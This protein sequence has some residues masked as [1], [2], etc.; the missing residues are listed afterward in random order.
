M[1][2]ETYLLAWIHRAAEDSERGGGTRPLKK[3]GTKTPPQRA[4]VG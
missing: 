3:L 4:P 1:F 2:V